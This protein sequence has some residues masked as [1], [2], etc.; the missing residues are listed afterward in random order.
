MGETSVALKQGWTDRAHE[1]TRP[2]VSSLGGSAGVLGIAGVPDQAPLSH[3]VL[4]CFSERFC[5]EAH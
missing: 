1:E 3:S 5:P 2:V 4:Q